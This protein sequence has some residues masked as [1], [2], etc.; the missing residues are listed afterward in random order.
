MRGIIF[1]FHPV[2]SGDVRTSLSFSAWERSP[3]FV[4][5][6]GRERKLRVPVLYFF[7]FSDPK[8]VK[9]LRAILLAVESQ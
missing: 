8:Q 5:A 1:L 6:D 2:S 3:G 9:K 7:F 4:V